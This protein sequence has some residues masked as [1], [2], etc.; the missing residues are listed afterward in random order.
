MRV[1]PVRAQGSAGHCLGRQQPGDA[2]RGR[3]AEAARERDLVV[4][5]DAHHRRLEAEL[6]QAVLEPDQESV[7]GIEADL[8]GALPFDDE[9]LGA[10][11]ERGDRHAQ[12]QIEREG[13]AVE[14][15]AEIGR[16]RRAPRLG[17]AGSAAAVCSP[18]QGLAN[19]GR[20]SG[21][22]GA[23]ARPCAAAVSGSFRP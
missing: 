13:E 12:L 4:H 18:A 17:W 11:F 20:A 16:S 1:Q 9:L 5:L 23:S 8:V 22:L 21:R 10:G 7:S 2:G 6:L 3:R 14:A 15:W 19:A